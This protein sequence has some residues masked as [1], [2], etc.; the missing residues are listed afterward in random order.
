MKEPVQLYFI[1]LCFFLLQI[2]MSARPKRP[3]VLTAATTHWAPTPACVTLPTNWDLMESSVTV[4]LMSSYYYMNRNIRFICDKIFY[5]S[6]VTHKISLC[7]G[8]EMEIV[9]SCEN[10]NGGCS[11]HCQHSTSGPVCSCNHGYRLDDDLKTCVGT[12]PRCTGIDLTNMLL[13]DYKAYTWVIP[14]QQLNY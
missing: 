2:S 3:T 13:T 4:S 5:F 11:H 10:N 14:T 6:S 1:F 8:I 12:K 9:N 7:K